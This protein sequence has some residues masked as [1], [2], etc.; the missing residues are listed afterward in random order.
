M[1]GYCALHGCTYRRAEDCP[2][3]RKESLIDLTNRIYE[4]H[5][6]RADWIPMEGVTL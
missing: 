1:T 3:C 4:R 6:V 2:E 5:V